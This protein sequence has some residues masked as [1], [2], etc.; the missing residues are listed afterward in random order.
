[1]GNAAYARVSR[2][3]SSDLWQVVLGAW[4]EQHCYPVAK[5]FGERPSRCW[6][7]GDIPHGWACAD[8]MLLV[9]DILF[10]EADEDGDAQIFLA[11]GVMPHWL[12]DGE[13]IEVRDAPTVFGQSF[14]YRLTHRRSAQRVDVQIIQP[15]PPHVRFVYPCRFGT[16]VQSATANGN[17]AA[18]NGRDVSLPRGT[19]QAAI[20]YS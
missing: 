16:G 13:S 15:P 14:G 6:Y 4:N 10:F 17:P 20:N 18:V 7:M 19:T 9:R 3:N 12:S 5:N 2:E 11:P 8:F 1:V